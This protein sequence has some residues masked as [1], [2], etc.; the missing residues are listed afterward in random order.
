MT[1]HW[2]EN[3]EAYTD[4]YTEPHPEAVMRCV[5]CGEAFPDEVQPP[6]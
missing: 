5:E 4:N 3:C 1:E 2:C 6:I